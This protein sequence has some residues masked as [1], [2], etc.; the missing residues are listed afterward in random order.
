MQGQRNDE[1][2]G[3]LS[4]HGADLG[5]LI[6]FIAAAL[7]INAGSEKNRVPGGAGDP[8]IISGLFLALFAAIAWVVRKPPP[9]NQSTASESIPPPLPRRDDPEDPE[10]KGNPG[11]YPSLD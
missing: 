6:V 5:L 7:L 1:K 10:N 2:R 3:C 9:R 11:I 4:R 8:H